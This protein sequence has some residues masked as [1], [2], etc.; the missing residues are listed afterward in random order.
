MKIFK[1]FNYFFGQFSKVEIYYI[2]KWNFISDCYNLIA[3][4]ACQE[5]NEGDGNDQI[6]YRDDCRTI[7]SICSPLGLEAVNVSFC[8]NGTE[9]TPLNRIITRVLS[10]EEFF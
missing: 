5:S 6:F 4:I 10:S 1:N 8:L 2:N 7:D 9:Y 3:D